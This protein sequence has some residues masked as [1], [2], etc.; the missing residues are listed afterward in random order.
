MDVKIDKENL[1]RYLVSK[2]TNIEDKIANTNNEQIKDFYS[3]QV[4]LLNKIALELDLFD[5]E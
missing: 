4:D 1:E 2:R 5:E 3:S